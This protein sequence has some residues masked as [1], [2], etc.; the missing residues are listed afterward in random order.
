[1][2][3]KLMA[4]CGVFVVLL[5]LP[6]TAVLAAGSARTPEQLI[7]NLLTAAQQGDVNSFLSGLSTDTRKAITQSYANRAALAQAQAAFQA[8]LDEKFGAPAK[9]IDTPPDDLKAAIGRL[10]A[11]EI[12]SKKQ[13]SANIAELRVKATTKLENEKTVSVE[14]TL[15]ARQEG[16][17]WK[18]DLG[19]VVDEKQFAEKKAAAEH[20]AER[21]RKGEY[22]DR[23][24]AMVALDRAWSR[25]EAK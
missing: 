17:A 18:L 2:Q 7:Q 6:I 1:M 11:A 15:R 10:V 20:I 19:L 22:K 12:L 3:I 8:A 25:K 24:A 13:V 4:R 14:Q 9:T 21:V 23:I 5:L 16:G